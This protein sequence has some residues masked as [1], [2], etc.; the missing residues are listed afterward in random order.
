LPDRLPA[1]SGVGTE[2]LP[3]QESHAAMPQFY[4]VPQ[5]QFRRFVVIQNNICKTRHV[6]MTGDINQR[7]RQ[8]SL[9]WRIHRDQPIN[10][11]FY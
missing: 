1:R 6:M 10:A 11:P 5:R 8:A 7:Q 2:R 9:K 4:Q 3:L